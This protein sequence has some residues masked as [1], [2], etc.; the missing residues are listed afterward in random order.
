MSSHWSMKR[1]LGGQIPNSTAVNGLDNECV[2]FTQP[3][4]I[5]LDNNPD[6]ELDDDEP[7]HTTESNHKAI[8]ARWSKDE[9]AAYMEHL[10]ALTGQGYFNI[11]RGVTWRP[12]FFLLLNEIKKV[13]PNKPWTLESMRA[14]RK[15]EKKRWI[16]Y[17]ALINDYTSGDG[18]DKSGRPIVSDQQWAR[19]ISK[20]PTGKRLRIIPLGN[21][22]I[23]ARAFPNDRS[24]GG[25]MR[26][27]GN[28]TPATRTQKTDDGLTGLPPSQQAT[29]S[30]TSRK[31]QRGH[32]LDLLQKSTDDSYTDSIPTRKRKIVKQELLRQAVMSRKRNMGLDATGFGLVYLE[33]IRELNRVPGSGDIEKAIKYCSEHLFPNMDDEHFALACEVLCIPRAAVVFNCLDEDRKL[34][35]LENRMKRAA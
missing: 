12:A 15:I 1:E 29:P 17:Q 19:F 11:D 8:R 2:I 31:R 21:K 26:A 23:Y 24:T 7:E 35:Y 14:K 16:E 9:T 10:A 28:I 34:R 4:P 30:Q 25:Y 27:A 13:S 6:F 20:Y 5:L 18:V 3:D 33:S 22:E 32:D